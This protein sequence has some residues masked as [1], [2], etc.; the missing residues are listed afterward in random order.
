MHRHHPSIPILSKL[1][2]KTAVFLNELVIACEAHI[3]LRAADFLHKAN[4][5][6]ALDNDFLQ[7]APSRVPYHRNIIISYL[8]NL[9]FVKNFRPH[10]G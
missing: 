10:D 9:S 8:H 6:C 5:S 7:V 1:H 2:P 4:Q 3:F